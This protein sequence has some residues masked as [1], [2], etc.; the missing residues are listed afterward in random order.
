MND[1]DKKYWS[2]ERKLLFPL[3]YQ[4]YLKYGWYGS[5]CRNEKGEYFVGEETIEQIR[6]MHKHYEREMRLK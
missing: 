5:V 6:M 4:A 3:A 1:V 2:E